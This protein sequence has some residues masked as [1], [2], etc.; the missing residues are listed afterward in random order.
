MSEANV[1]D[2]ERIDEDNPEWS[3]GEIAGAVRVSG[4][5]AGLRAK[6]RGRPKASV[7]KE[8]ITIRLSRDVLARFRASGPG[9]QTRM[10]AVLKDW[11]AGAR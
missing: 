11:L 1:I 3:S 4:L 9:W 7:T 8:R 2:P 5:P 10:D 6:L